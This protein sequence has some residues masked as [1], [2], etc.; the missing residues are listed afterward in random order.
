M[1]RSGCYVVSST[2]HLPVAPGIS[3][4]SQ[5]LIDEIIDYFQIICPEEYYHAKKNGD[6]LRT[7]ALISR[8]FRSRSQKHLFTY[9]GVEMWDSNAAQSTWE[10]LKDVFSTN[11]RLA[12]HVKI[13]T[14]TIKETDD[15]WSQCF[16]HPNFLACL[17]HMTESGG[18]RYPRL[19]ALQIHLTTEA[20]SCSTAIGL[21]TA[22]SDALIDPKM[23]FI[24]SSVT[25][26]LTSIEIHELH[27]VPVALFDTCHNL[28]KLNISRITLAPFEESKRIPIEK[29]PLI[30][31]LLVDGGEDLI[32]RT[33]LRFDKLERLVFQGA[34]EDR[35]L[36]YMRHIF[37]GAGSNTS[38]LEYLNFFLPRMFH[39]LC[40]I[41]QATTDLTPG[42]PNQRRMDAI[43]SIPTCT[44]KQVSIF[45]GRLTCGN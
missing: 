33:G 7:C 42:Y 22:W 29:R 25:S 14:L 16:G 30:R 3:Q 34:L 43:S 12:S 2:M 6:G 24:P 36:D 45:L 31:E 37:R 41:L 8:A 20:Y 35:D 17:A 23:C 44:P 4:L 39:Q 11:P 15:L 40:L 38:S 13:L 1:N 18:D 19:C 32:C 9:I 5:E 10:R 26:R 28:T 27:N 21:S